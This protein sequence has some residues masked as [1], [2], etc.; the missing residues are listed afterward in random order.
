VITNRFLVGF[1]A[2]AV[3]LRDS[4]KQSPV[5]FLC[6]QVGG[7]LLVSAIGVFLKTGLWSS[8]DFIVGLAILCWGLTYRLSDPEVDNNGHY[9]SRV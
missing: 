6:Y 7:F 2:G 4:L 9:S 5:F 1:Y 3:W 8:D